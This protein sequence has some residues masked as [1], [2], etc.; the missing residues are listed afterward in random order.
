MAIDPRLPAT[1]L[2]V[3]LCWTAAVP[4]SDPGIGANSE[5]PNVLYITP[6][7]A[8]ETMHKP[9]K[10]KL[11]SLYGDLFDP[12]DPLHFEAFVDVYV[13]AP[14]GDTQPTQASQ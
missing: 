14:A 1:S 3:A 2:L 4:A 8:P 13:T 11:H 5:L 12:I 10:L 7:R 6:W 9:P